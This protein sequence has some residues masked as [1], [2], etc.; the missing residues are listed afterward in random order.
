MEELCRLSGG[1]ENGYGSVVVALRGFKRRMFEDVG[2]TGYFDQ[3][4]SVRSILLAGRLF[5]AIIPF[6]CVPRFSFSIHLDN[7]ELYELWHV[8]SA[9]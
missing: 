7:R 8:A 6:P 5:S 9:D 3:F 4:A 1:S 2:K